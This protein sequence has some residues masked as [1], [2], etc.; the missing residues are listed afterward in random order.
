MFEKL[1]PVL[2]PPVCSRHP[3]PHEGGSGSGSEVRAGS[4]ACGVGRPN[5]R[6]GR[7]SRNGFMPA[8][9]RRV[10]GRR[11]QASRSS[12]SGAHGIGAQY[13]RP[14]GTTTGRQ[15]L[16]LL[17]RT[18]R[19]NG[20]RS[21]VRS[22]STACGTRQTETAAHEAPG[23]R[24]FKFRYGRSAPVSSHLLF[25]ARGLRA[26]AM[27]R[28][29]SRKRNLSR[30]IELGGRRLRAGGSGAIKRRI[31]VGGII[32][33]VGLVVVILAILSFLGLR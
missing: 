8:L 22:R 29:H 10:A 4:G 1:S 33:L 12:S 21:P 13:N 14:P 16:E 20:R 25:L 6:L 17:Y 2:R 18:R 19:H 23:D 11:A 31:P 24:S 30:C 26:A 15:R 32:Y 27:T 28:V 7:L 3:R 9:V 5:P